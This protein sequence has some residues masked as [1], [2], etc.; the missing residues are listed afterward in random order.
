VNTPIII[1]P[2]FSEQQQQHCLNIITI[3]VGQI[4]DSYLRTTNGGNI[5]CIKTFTQ[6]EYS[7]S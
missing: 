6:I 4:K 5:C 1:V 2:V 7:G 3:L